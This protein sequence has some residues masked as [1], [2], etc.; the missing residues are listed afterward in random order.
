MD[1]AMAPV[2]GPAVVVG[3]FSGEGMHGARDA[4]RLI[5]ALNRPDV[6]YAGVIGS[7]V[8]IEGLVVRSVA[9]AVRAAPGASFGAKRPFIEIR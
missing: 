2:E 8:G 3:M 5:A 6:I 1:E 9:E 7:V 4:P